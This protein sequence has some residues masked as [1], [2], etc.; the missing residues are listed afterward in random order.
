MENFAA[1]SSSHNSASYEAA[2]WTGSLGDALP[3]AGFKQAPASENP[4]F[5]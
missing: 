3:D 4:L 1:T 5:L 2:L